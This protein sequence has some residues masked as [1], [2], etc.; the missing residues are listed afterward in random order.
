VLRTRAGGTLPAAVLL[1]RALGL[2]TLLFS[3]SSS[4]EGFHG[5]NE[6]FRLSRLHEGTDAWARLLDLLA[7]RL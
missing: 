4:D 3:F 2:D 7:E 1:R 6:F 5:P